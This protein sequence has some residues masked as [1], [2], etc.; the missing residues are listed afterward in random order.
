[1]GKLKLTANDYTP[2]GQNYN[3]TTTPETKATANGGTVQIFA[4]GNFTYTPPNGFQGID[5]FNYTVHNPNGSKVGLAKVS[6]IPII[7]IKLTTSDNKVNGHIGDPYYSR[8]MD[9]ILN[10]Y[11]DS[12]G[13]IPFNVSGFGFRVI[14]NEFHSVKVNG[15]SSSYNQKWETDELTGTNTKI[16]D[17]FIYQDIQD[18]PNLGDNSEENITITIS[19]GAYNKI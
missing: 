18:D 3:Y 6:V 16:L 19:A 11:S 8:S 4:D 12:A 17:D 7:Y 9:Y 13:T 14:I 1:M 5:K 2:D 15:N 10:F